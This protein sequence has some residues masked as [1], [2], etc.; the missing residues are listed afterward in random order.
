MPAAMLI[1]KVIAERTAAQCSRS[2]LSGNNLDVR[3]AKAL[4]TLAPPGNPAV[5]T[6]HL[7]GRL[8]V[9]FSASPDS[10]VQIVMY[11]HRK[12]EVRLILYCRHR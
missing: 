12:Q 3:W 2:A 1:V 7:A 11:I 5:V 6:E 4:A 10:H 8:A 9:S